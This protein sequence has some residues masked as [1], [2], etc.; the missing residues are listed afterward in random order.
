MDTTE[1]FAANAGGHHG[2]HEI[3]VTVVGIQKV[4]RKR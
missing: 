4:A 2:R 3:Q 1:N